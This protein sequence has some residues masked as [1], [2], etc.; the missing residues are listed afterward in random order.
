MSNTIITDGVPTPIVAGTAPFTG[1][2]RAQGSL[3][4]AFVNKPAQGTWRLELRDNTPN[5]L[6]GD[7]KSWKLYLNH[8]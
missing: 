2:F 4:G 8:R 3:T 1:L 7:L 5:G 6:Q